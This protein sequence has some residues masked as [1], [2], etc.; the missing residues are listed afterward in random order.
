VRTVRQSYRIQS[1]I[2]AL[3][4]RGV[5]QL[6]T[7]RDQRDVDILARGIA[8]TVLDGRPGSA[9]GPSKVVYAMEWMFVSTLH[10]AVVSSIKS[11]KTRA[12]SGTYASRISPGRVSHAPSGM[13][14]D[15]VP[16]FVG[17]SSAPTMPLSPA[18]EAK[19]HCNRRSY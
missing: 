3:D 11:S 1:P 17:P 15:S 13:A 12:L 14:N 4:V 7:H 18:S 8:P 10:L 2:G 16:A 9:C 19:A 6:P 5:C